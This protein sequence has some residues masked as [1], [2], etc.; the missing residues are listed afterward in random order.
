MISLKQCVIVEGKY[1]KQKLQGLIDATILS[2]EG[3]RIFKD[4]EKRLLIRTMAE[5][6]GLIVL[7]DSDRAGFLIRNHI[8]GLVPSEKITNVYIPEIRGKEKRKPTVSKEG[9]LGVEGIEDAVLIKAFEQAGITASPTVSPT[10]RITKLDLYEAGL[11]GSPNS[12]KLRQ[13]LLKEL[14]LPHYI[15]S[16]AMLDILN[17]MLC[18]EDFMNLIHQIKEN[19]EGILSV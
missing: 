12:S 4:Q 5:K 15:T 10:R 18:Y 8:K 14:A 3:F 13:A 11:S 19:Q 17:A 1:D 7:T 2:T 9:L 16:N 6:N